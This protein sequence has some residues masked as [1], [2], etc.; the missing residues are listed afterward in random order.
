MVTDKHLKS[1]TNLEN[2]SWYAAYLIFAAAVFYGLKVFSSTGAVSLPMLFSAYAG[3]C[4]SY[5][6]IVRCFRTIRSNPSLVPVIIL[7]ILV[8]ILFLYSNVVLTGDMPRYLWEGRLVS[9]GISPYEFAPNEPL[10]TPLRTSDWL[11]IE[12]THLSA[13]YPPVAELLLSVFARSVSHWKGFLLG[14]ELLTCLL[15]ARALKERMLPI[16]MLTYY[17]L[18]PLPI[19]EIAHSGHLEGLLSLFLV[20][21]VLSFNR[22]SPIRSTLFSG[23]LAGLAITTK[24]VG[25]A[26]LLLAFGNYLRRKQ[27]NAALAMLL[28]AAIVTTVL[29][30]PFLDHDLSVFRSLSAY[31][32]HWQFND[33]LLYFLGTLSNADWS[34]LH[35]FQHLKHGLFVLWLVTAIVIAWQEHDLA[36]QTIYVLAVY[37]LCSA[38]VH[39]WYAL[40]FAALLCL[41][42]STSML[43]LC[44]ML[45]LSYQSLLN[46]GSPLSPLVRAIEYLPVYALLFVGIWRRVSPKPIRERSCP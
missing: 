31:L 24:Y 6:F 15:L 43:C 8:R 33:S 17:F 26:P 2:G 3:W 27:V 44:L 41:H 40:W 13:I 9:Q 19:L 14:C 30:L 35:S 39:P 23:V 37:L 29:F 22:K 46:G 36:R 11:Q 21:F 25:L 10:L 5:L 12:Y 42:P 4:V 18:M 34:N 38:T 28:T 20:W 1:K 16:G 45:P 7:A 32:A